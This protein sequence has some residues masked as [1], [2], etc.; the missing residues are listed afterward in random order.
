[1]S[2]KPRV[3]V[4]GGCGFVGR[5]LVQYLVEKDLA[6]KVRVADKMLPALAGLS[7][8]QKEIFA[9][10]ESK[11]VNLS[12][13]QTIA[14]VFD[15]DAPFDLVFNCAGETKYS[16]ADAVYQENIIDVSV[17]SAKE[18]AKRGVK[19][20]I[21]VSTAQVY[22]SSSKSKKEEAKIKPW[23]GIAKAKFKA[24]E[25]LKA[26][27]GLNLI[28]VRPATIYGPGDLN[29]IT[30][31]LITAAVYKSL[32]EKMEFLWDK[33]L[34]CNTVHVR[35]VVAAMWHLTQNGKIGSVYNLADSGNTSQGS[36]CPILESLFGIRTGFIGNL[37]SK[38]A[39]SLAMKVVAETANDKHLK[40]WSDL[41]KE[42]KITT[43]PLTPYL[44]EELLYDNPLCVDGSAIVATGYKYQYP[45]VT[46]DLVKESLE[47]FIQINFFPA[48]LV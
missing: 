36:L 40:P 8:K 20:F 25:A 28:I 16:Q 13:P 30:P 10:I 19:I 43:T 47:Y 44:D 11:Q 22:D 31:R 15:D 45:Q 35:D 12:R 48:G 24:E 3:L 29:G 21:E 33:D 46:S 39:T 17:T 37:K 26:I 4:L 6:S 42:H 27:S 7:E 32:K 2:A 18:A 1:M 34:E 5:N 38:M 9:K 14:K 41:C 23:T